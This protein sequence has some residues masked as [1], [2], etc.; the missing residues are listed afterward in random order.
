MQ[1]IPCHIHL[2]RTQGNN[3]ATIPMPHTLSHN[4]GK[5]LCNHSHAKYT[6]TQHRETTVQQF[7]C[8]IHFHTTQ[9]NNCATIPMQHTLT[10]HRETTVLPCNTKPHLLL[11]LHLRSTCGLV[12]S[13]TG[14]AHTNQYSLTLY[15][16]GLNI[17]SLLRL[18]P[19]A[20]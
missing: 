13:S 9:G 11:L 7:P 17:R 19:R 6:F 3:C 15:C 16:R 8:K 10:Q 1:Q 18:M 2:H 20:P 14:Y 5:Q 4:T 12:E